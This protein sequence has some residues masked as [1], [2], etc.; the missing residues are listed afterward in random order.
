VN[1]QTKRMLQRQGQVDQNG[2][3][4]PGTREAP[5]PAAG[6]RG[7]GGPAGGGPKDPPT[8]GSAGARGRRGGG[9][10]VQ[11]VRDVRGELLRVAWG[12]RDE[13]VSYT[14]VVVVTLIVLV[15]F[16][17]LLNLGFARA[18]SALFGT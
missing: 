12:T 9:G 15:S 8:G 1:R 10:P 16:V 13:V 17:F 14:G 5:R 4:V 11:F 18:I 3:P 6:R 7:P 2:A